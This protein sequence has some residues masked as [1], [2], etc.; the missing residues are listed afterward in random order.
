MDKEIWYIQTMKYYVTFKKK[1]IRS[2]VTIWI[3]FKNIVLS[4]ISQWQKDKYV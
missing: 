1:E 4:E 2:H 3:N